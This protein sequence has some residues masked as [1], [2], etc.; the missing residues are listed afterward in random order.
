M[1]ASDKIAA[2]IS[3][4]EEVNKMKARVPVALSL[5]LVFLS[6]LLASLT[7]LAPTGEMQ[8]PYDPPTATRPG[9]NVIITPD[10]TRVGTFNVPAGKI[11]VT[12]PDDMR[13]GDTI[14]GTVMAEPTGKTESERAANSN[15]L[16]KYVIAI[17]MP[18]RVPAP[19]LVVTNIVPVDP[20]ARNQPITFRATVKNTASLFLMPNESAGPCR[21][22]SSP[23][24]AINEGCSP[25]SQLVFT[26][27]DRTPIITAN[28]NTNSIVSGIGN[29]TFANMPDDANVPP[30][31][32]KMPP[33]FGNDSPRVPRVGQAG[34]PLVIVG[35]FDGNGSNTGVSVGPPPEPQLFPSVLPIPPG[36]ICPIIAESPRKT[37][38]EIP[39]NVVGPVSLNV[40][41]NGKR[42][43]AP[44]RSVGVNLSAPKTSLMRGEKTTLT[45]QVSGLQ[46]IREPVP[47]TLT[48]GGVITMQGGV[49]QPLQIQ[50][51]QV[52]SNGTYTTTREITGVQTGGWNATATVVKGPFDA[53]IVDSTNPKP[54]I[55]LNT[56]TGDYAFG[57]NTGP[58]LAGQGKPVMKGCIITL[59]H[60]AP[61]RRVFAQL[62][63]CKTS[64]SAKIETQT[65]KMNFTIND[66]NITDN[67]CG[68]Q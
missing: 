31:A 17:D 39:P 26:D 18:F 42:T 60:N 2:I 37:I 20:P 30:P 65:P 46:G 21:R 24:E 7:Y 45:V 19:D 22:P 57:S 16:K 32:N 13:A 36:T 44:F 33:L 1:R 67:V 66:T 59:T 40:N 58:V 55:R 56:F 50:P 4:R 51:S 52:N 8:T 34:R 3:F 64:G 53:C 5:G 62:D 6:A 9:P 43:T 15:E 10:E 23:L 28:T 35:P 61:D 47:L 29:T 48:C 68:S 25:I 11:T 49:F 27:P 63:T 12:L 41:E 54:V 38:V 14:T